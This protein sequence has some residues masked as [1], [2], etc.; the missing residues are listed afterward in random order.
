MR[1]AVHSIPAYCSVVCCSGM[2]CAVVGVI[3]TTLNALLCMDGSCV[4]VMCM[5]YIQVLYDTLDVVNC[6]RVATVTGQK[7]RE[8]M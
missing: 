3:Y 2:C 5:F 4:I 6:R 7:M 8:R 1:V